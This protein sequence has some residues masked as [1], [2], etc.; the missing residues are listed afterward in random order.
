MPS[1]ASAPPELYTLSLHDALPISTVRVDGREVDMG[2]LHP[3]ELDGELYVPLRPVAGA[4]GMRYEHHAGEDLFALY[5][6]DGRLRGL[7]GSRSEERRVGTEGRARGGAAC[8][9]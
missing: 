3:V 6:P 8:L 5:T 7:A 1:S 2:S 9:K 4:A